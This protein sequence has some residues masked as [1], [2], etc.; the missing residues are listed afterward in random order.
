MKTLYRYE[1]RYT[2]EDNETEIVLREYPVLRETEY[3][4]Y[5]HT[6][7]LG[8]PYDKRWNKRIKKGAMNTYA[9][10]TKEKAKENFINRT[11]NRIRWY[12]FWIDECEKGLKL[13]KNI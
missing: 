11:T 10:D 1:I 12:R 2:T 9:Y 8:I 13:I 5:I 3:S 7:V 6:Y 4:Y